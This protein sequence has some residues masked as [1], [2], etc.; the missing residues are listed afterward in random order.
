MAKKKNDSKKTDS[1]KTDS[2]K[3]DTKAKTSTGK[4]VAMAVGTAAAAVAVGAAVKKA[5]SS[6][7]TVYEVKTHDDGWQVIKDGASRASSVH[8]TKKEAVAEAREL[9]ADRAPSELH[10]YKQ[11]GELD[12]SHSYEPEEE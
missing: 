5:V 1:K 2:K 8:P 4:A 10:I 9:A 12:D 6:G 11:D 3:T 7:K